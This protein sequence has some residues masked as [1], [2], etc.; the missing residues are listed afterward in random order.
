[1]KR[2]VMQVGDGSYT[3]SLP[4]AW[5]EQHGIKRGDELE[6]TQ[7]ENLLEVSTERKKPLS[8]MV[9][10]ITGLDR[11]SIFYVLRSAYR[12]GYDVIKVIFDQKTTVHYRT[13]QKVLVASLL[14]QELQR[15]I[16]MQIVEQKENY[17]I[18]KSISK[19]S[20]EEFDLMLRR[21]FLL[22]IDVGDGFVKAVEQGD[23]LQLETMDDTFYNLLI[24]ITYC[25][26]LINKVGF[27]ERYKNCVL[28]TVLINLNKIGDILRYGARDALKL[29]K[30]LNPKSVKILREVFQ[31]V[32]FYYDLFYK[33]NFTSFSKVYQRRDILLRQ[34]DSIKK[35]IPVEE[36]MLLVYCRQVLEIVVSNLEATATYYLDDKK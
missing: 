5:C 25:Q 13:E 30:K 35:S 23:S 4:K 7:Q 14:H 3:L 16:G 17:F 21:T 11:T 10:N 18:Y 6:V 32:H 24:F 28:Y 20:F 1:M 34:I 22:L 2:S 36:L 19:P 15:W 9:I 8:E 33:F 26:R 29:K 27:P 12:Q 31:T